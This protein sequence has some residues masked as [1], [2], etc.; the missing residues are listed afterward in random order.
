MTTPLRAGIAVSLLAILAGGTLY[1]KSQLFGGGRGLLPGLKVGGEVVPDDVANADDA[2]LRAWIEEREKP[3]LDR[4]VEIRAEKSSRTVS[5]RTLVV[6][7]DASGIV[8]RLRSLGHES[9][10]SARIDV[11]LKARRGEIDVPL[12]ITP[13]PTAIEHVVA[14]LK[15]EI[16]APPTDAKLDLSAHTTFADTPG[17][18]LDFDG[19]AVTLSEYVAHHWHDASPADG[20]KPQ[21]ELPAITVSARVTAESLRKLDISTVLASFETHFGRGGDQAPR[22]T[23]IENA[24]KKLDGLVLEPQ[25]LVSFNAVVG[26]RSE[27]NGFKIAWE[28]FK[29][30]MRP[31]VG[32]GTCQVASTLHAAAFFA[33]FDILE[34]LPH[35][36]PSAYIP[37]GLDSTVVFPSTDLKLKNPYPFSVVVHTVVSANTLKIEL[38]G[39]EKPVSVTFS[40]DTAAVLPYERRIDEESYVTAGKAIKKQGGIRGYRIKRVR[41]ITALTEAGGSVG[42]SRTEESFDFYPPTVEI[43]VVA[44]GTDP[45][46]LPAMPEDVVAALA[47]KKG[48]APPE[49]ATT[50]AVACAGDCEGETKPKVEVLNGAGVHAATGDQV[51]PMPKV[52]IKQ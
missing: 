3:F 43:Y 19:G 40:R 18:F 21:I 20:K 10:L 33:G 45:N 2:T 22:A 31:G 47:K 35:S 36:R 5:L 23:N 48:E 25:Q 6:P 38:L 41:V 30:E 13:D 26:E 42:E 28:I 50:D 32:G 52:L 27:A 44:P 34:R 15:A 37:M 9:T 11:A 14:E 7:P 8:A 51:A 16:D 39:K 1:A 4:D 12:S 46:E 17:H 29:G 49:Y 24:S